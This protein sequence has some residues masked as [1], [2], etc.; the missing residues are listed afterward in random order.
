MF[1]Q[2]Y[3]IQEIKKLIVESEMEGQV[4]TDDPYYPALEALSDLEEK[5]WD[6]IEDQPRIVSKEKFIESA[7]ADFDDRYK[8]TEQKMR[9][10][11][12]EA[13]DMGHLYG[14]GQEHQAPYELAVVIKGG[15]FH[16][17][18]SS[19]P[20]ITVHKIDIDE[21]S[22]DAVMYSTEQPEYLSAFKA[23]EILTHYK[24]QF[25]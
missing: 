15:T 2:I 4:D 1:K 13:F 22:E 20:S 17:I 7:L 8:M 3:Y 10:E 16:K 25:E 18:L 24:N 6:Q 19:R 5:I 14:V 11:L 12:G 23:K 9:N 21:H